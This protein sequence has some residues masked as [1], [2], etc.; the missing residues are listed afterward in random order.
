MSWQRMCEQI[1]FGSVVWCARKLNLPGYSLNGKHRQK[2]QH[3]TNMETLFCLGIQGLGGHSWEK[4]GSGM[5]CLAG[6][7]NLKRES[8]P[9][10]SLR[11]S[12]RWLFFVPLTKRTFVQSSEATTPKMHFCFY[13][14]VNSSVQVN[15]RPLHCVFWGKISCGLL[16]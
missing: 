10:L 4:A 7:K 11:V 16:F 12:A 15:N 3:K 9:V 14:S 1:N 6:R 13:S 8:I 5:H 2:A